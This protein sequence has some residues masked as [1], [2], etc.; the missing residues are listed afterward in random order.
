M[1]FNSEYW[2]LHLFA[3]LGSMYIG[4]IFPIF[5]YLLS[6]IIDILSEIEE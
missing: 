6:Q 1:K 5:A 3:I 2:Y 4:C